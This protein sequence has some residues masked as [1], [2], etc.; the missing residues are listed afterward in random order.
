MRFDE[1]FR[2]VYPLN[3]P[4][5]FLSVRLLHGANHNIMAAQSGADTSCRDGTQEQRC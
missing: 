4:A 1:A 2:I 5:M 3:V